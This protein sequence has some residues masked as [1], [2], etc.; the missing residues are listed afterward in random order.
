M[1]GFLRTQ[2]QT[3]SNT[4]A[5]PPH[6][7]RKL[8]FPFHFNVILAEIV[9]FQFNHLL[10]CAKLVIA[11]LV[12]ITKLATPTLVPKKDHLLKNT[13][14][15]SQLLEPVLGREKILQKEDKQRNQLQRGLKSLYRWTSGHKARQVGHQNGSHLV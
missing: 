10:N 14:G 11:T 9:C 12:P 3:G 13:S 2:F 5:W 4:V 7:V 15:I 8:N 1:S 6:C